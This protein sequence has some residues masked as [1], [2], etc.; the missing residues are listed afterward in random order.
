ML[1]LAAACVVGLLFFNACLVVVLTWPVSEFS[2]AKAGALGDSFG[3]LNAV[4]SGL[5]F[6]GVVWTLYQQ[7][8]E[9]ADA[10][11]STRLDRF[12]GTFFQLVGM[13]RRNLGEI[14]VARPEGGEAVMGIDALAYYSRHITLQLKTHE[15]WLRVPHGRLVY[16]RM[17]Q[18]YVRAMPLQ[19]RYLGTLQAI[20]EL[21]ERDLSDTA[22][23]MSYWGLLA[24]QLTAAECKY[25]LLLSLRA[26]Q[27]DALSQLLKNAGPI[28]KRIEECNVGEMQRELFR[29]LHGITLSSRPTHYDD[30]LGG[31]YK[32]IRKIARR[33]LEA[34]ERVVRP[35]RRS[36]QQ[37]PDGQA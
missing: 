17:I 16:Q 12:E 29:R 15:R 33:E 8:E 18:R 22:Q 35:G 37:H 36:T 26:R 32:K 19:G 3:W 13:L 31:D 1:R 28:L 5:A 11:A 34:F 24:S 4:F 27:D 7:K 30:L 9:L 6:L 23:K 14:R 20:L 25:L 10:R 2:V 21:I